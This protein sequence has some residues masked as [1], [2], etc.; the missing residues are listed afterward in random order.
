MSALILSISLL[1]WD[2]TRQL[3][4]PPDRPEVWLARTLARHAVPGRIIE[5]LVPLDRGLAR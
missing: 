4:P 2:P 1:R 5:W 3:P